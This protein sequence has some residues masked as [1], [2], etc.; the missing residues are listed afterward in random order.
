MRKFSK[1]SKCAKRSIA[2][3]IAAALAS[4]S[5]TLTCSSAHKKSVGDAGDELKWLVKELTLD[6]VLGG[7]VEVAEKGAT[8]AT[9]YVINISDRT[10]K[11]DDFVGKTPS[12][13]GVFEKCVAADGKLFT[14]PANAT[15]TDKL[16]TTRGKTAK[17]WAAVDG[18]TLWIMHSADTS[19]NPDA[20]ALIVK[21]DVL[22]PGLP[23]NTKI[24]TWKQKNDSVTIVENGVEKTEKV[25][26][27][28]CDTKFTGN[29]HNGL[30]LTNVE[31]VEIQDALDLD[32]NTIYVRPDKLPIKNEEKYII[33]LTNRQTGKV[34]T[35]TFKSAIKGTKNVTKDIDGGKITL[36]TSEPLDYNILNLSGLKASDDQI[37]LTLATANDKKLSENH[38][39]LLKLTSDHI[40]AEPESISYLKSDTETIK[41]EKFTFDE[42]TKELTFQIT[43]LGQYLIEPKTTEQSNETTPKNSTEDADKNTKDTE[44]T[45]DNEYE[46]ENDANDSEDA[47]DTTPTPSQTSNSDTKTHN[48]PQTSSSTTS[49]S[50]STSSMLEA[51]ANA[52]DAQKAIVASTIANNIGSVSEEALSKMNEDILGLAL[53]DAASGTYKLAGKTADG[54]FIVK[55]AN[56]DGTTTEMQL[57]AG[58]FKKLIQDEKA[59]K[60]ASS[61]SVQSA[62]QA[63]KEATSASDSSEGKTS[64][65]ASASTSTASGS[66]VRSSGVKTGDSTHVLGGLATL[67]T[68]GF[69]LFLMKR[70]KDK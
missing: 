9:T 10:V 66:S 17:E 37:T 43:A 35:Y 52:T 20:A 22:S 30:T 32:A 8:T 19:D 56:A 59:K 1:G 45:T 26:I 5:L 60:T 27:V 55:K 64:K 48:V 15:N 58:E 4:T 54:K 2:I 14:A 42:S 62:A 25:P 67:L 49:Q 36:T 34:E 13:A 11:A 21:D 38:T 61:A 40:T 46:D 12:H 6:D 53:E 65:A 50:A 51:A 68:T 69:G 57:T 41:I 18:K 70:K 3:T 63:A 23:L 39:H 44:K 28:T 7:A 31:G 29:S 33:T 47:K 24:G 16:T